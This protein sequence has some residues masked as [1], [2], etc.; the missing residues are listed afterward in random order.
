MLL[1]LLSELGGSPPGSLPPPRTSLALSSSLAGCGRLAALQPKEDIIQQKPCKLALGK[2]F[3]PDWEKRAEH[4]G[5]P[6]SGRLRLGRSHL[7]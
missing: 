2:N 3:Q 5:L 6:L 4:S 1:T 7:A